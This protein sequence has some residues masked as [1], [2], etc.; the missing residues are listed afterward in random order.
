MSLALEKLGDKSKAICCAK[1]AL[2]IFEE[3]EDPKAERVKRTL[4]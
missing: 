1:S 3:I 4:Q 2:K